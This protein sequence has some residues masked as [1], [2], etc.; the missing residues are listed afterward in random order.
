[1]R[2]LVLVVFL[3]VSAPAYADTEAE[4]RAA[5]DFFVQVWN[6][7]DAEAIQG[8]YHSGFVQ[9][10]DSGPVSR[11]QHLQNILTLIHDGGDRGTLDYSD[12]VVEDLGDEHAMAYGHMALSFQDGSSIDRWFTTVYVKTPFGWKAVLTRN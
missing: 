11:E 5:L 6:E 8:Y 3:I 9:I 2:R 10:G 7:D 4:I 1:M 12:I